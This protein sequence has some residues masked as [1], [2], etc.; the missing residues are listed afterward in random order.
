MVT[1]SEKKKI[2]AHKF[3]GVGQLKIIPSGRVNQFRC[4]PQTKTP[5]YLTSSHFVHLLFFL[6]NRNVQNASVPGRVGEIP[7]YLESGS[8]QVNTGV[9]TYRASC[10]RNVQIKLYQRKFNRLAFGPISCTICRILKYR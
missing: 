1:I 9:G 8:W 3:A 2:T 6:M 10:H 4:Y 5:I 7:K